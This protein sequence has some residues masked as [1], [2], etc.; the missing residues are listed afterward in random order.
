MASRSRFKGAG[1]QGRAGATR[2]LR[3]FYAG[4]STW[5]REGSATSHA[6]V[7]SRSDETDFSRI[8]SSQ[9]KPPRVSPKFGA[10]SLHAIGAW[11]QPGA[12]DTRRAPESHLKRA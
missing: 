1:F 7:S 10:C 9:R 2:G 4:F 5:I 8:I 3:G 11:N 6:D 12:K